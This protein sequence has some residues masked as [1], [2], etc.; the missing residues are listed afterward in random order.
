[1]QVHNQHGLVYY[2]FA[3]LASQPLVQA[4][5]GRQGGVSPA[6]YASLNMSISTG[7]SLHNVRENRRRAYQAV[8][9]AET[10]IATLWQVHGAQVVVVNHTACDSDTQADA[11]VTNNPAISLFLRFADCVPILFYDPVQHAIGI[12]HA[13]WRGTVNGVQCAT[14]QAMQ[15]EYGSR[16]TDIIACIGPSIGPDI[17]A[18]GTEVEQ[19]VLSAVGTTAGLVLDKGTKRHLDLWQTN[20]RM[21]RQCGVEQIEIAELCTY[22]HSDLFFSHRA[23]GPTTGRFGALLKLAG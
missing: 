19:A 16:P 8:G 12:A 6:P 23:H 13:G 11:L 9:V 4:V 15:R 1:M 3:S 22:T 17:Y 5:F 7:D 21:L 2:T 18:V 10:P 20:A 14:V